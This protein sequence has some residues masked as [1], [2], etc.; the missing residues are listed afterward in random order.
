MCLPLCL[1]KM[2][3][4]NRRRFLAAGAAV[5]AG[6]M[7]RGEEPIL[8]SGNAVGL[9]QRVESFQFSRVVDLTHRLTPDFPTGSGQGQLRMERLATWPKDPWNMYRWHIHE[10]TGTHLDAPLHR[11]D[12]DSADLIPAAH[13]LGPLA[14]VDIRRKTEA[15]PDAEL[16]LDDLRAWESRHG[17]LG[18]G[19][20]VAMCSGWDKH[21]GTARFRNVGGNGE[22]HNPGFQIEAVEFLLAERDVK[23]IVVD[24]LSLD[25]GLSA[26]FPVHVRWLGSNR[27]G[28][29]CAANLGELPPKGATLI[30]GSPKIA[31]AS[32]GPS[33][34]FALLQ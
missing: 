34:V 7:G 26:D 16:T 10:H 11:S 13:L 20:I 29:E 24:T 23:G 1:E 31:G 12:R 22:L 5:A 15:D 6:A 28:L 17:P 27:W 8:G 2:R 30:V 3:S 19:S 33:R 32:G 9:A 14:V 21:V 18:P 25:R 4:M